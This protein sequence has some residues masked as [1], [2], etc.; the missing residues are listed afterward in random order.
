VRPL[1]DEA[2]AYDVVSRP[3]NYVGRMHARPA[4]TQKCTEIGASN[5]R[6]ISHFRHRSQLGAFSM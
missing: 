2:L 5:A 4:I 3:A 6:G 1:H